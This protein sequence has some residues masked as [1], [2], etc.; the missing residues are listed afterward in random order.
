M[1][2]SLDGMMESPTRDLDWVAIDEDFNRY[3]GGMLS[4]IDTILL[5]RVTYQVSWT[6]GRFQ[7]TPRRPQ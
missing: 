3:V 4:S 5:G 7:P 2:V 6:T 1:M